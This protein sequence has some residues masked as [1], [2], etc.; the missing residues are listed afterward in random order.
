M[1]TCN[2][3]TLLNQACANGFLQLA[4]TSPALA[5]AVINQLL[6]N[7]S[8]GSSGGS[9]QVFLYVGAAPPVI[10]PTDPTQP[11]LSYSQDGSGPIFGWNV[12]LQVWN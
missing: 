1:A 10:P 5:Q 2:Q 7:I 8:A 6:C 9:P 11:A 3:D 12:A 4:Q